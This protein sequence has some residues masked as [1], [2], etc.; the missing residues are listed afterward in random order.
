M[1]FI[2]RYGILLFNFYYLYQNSLSA[3]INVDSTIKT[4]DGMLC[5]ATNKFCLK[6]TT[7]NQYL[8]LEHVLVQNLSINT[9]FQK[10]NNSRV[11]F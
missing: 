5:G 3:I 9:Y 1:Y 8:L 6:D 7:D 4:I 11:D 2:N 10:N